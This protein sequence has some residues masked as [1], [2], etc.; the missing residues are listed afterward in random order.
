VIASTN[1]LIGDTVSV[2]MPSRGSDW[3]RIRSHR[4]WHCSDSGT[5]DIERPIEPLRDLLDTLLSRTGTGRLPENKQLGFLDGAKGNGEAP[6]YYAGDLS[7]LARPCVSIVGTRD[8][9]EAGATATVS[10][11]NFSGLPEHRLVPAKRLKV[12][13]GPDKVISDAG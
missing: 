8:V 1:P 13:P 6:I 2:Q 3:H 10:G 7:L 12:I 5:I 9:S 11:P 4:A